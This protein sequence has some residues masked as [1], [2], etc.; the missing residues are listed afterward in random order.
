MKRSFFL[1]LVFVCCAGTACAG[2]KKLA[3]FDFDDTS[4]S[5]NSATNYEDNPMAVFAM[6]RGQQPHQQD[7]PKIGKSVANILVT[8]LVKDGTFYRQQVLL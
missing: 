4:I 1:V 8:E 2:V 3:V 5:M 7:K 6:M